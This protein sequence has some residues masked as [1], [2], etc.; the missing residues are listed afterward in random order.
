MKYGLD[1]GSHSVYALQYHLVQVVKYRRKALVN[2]EIIDFLKQR[3][4]I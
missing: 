1:R 2:D 4:R 3:N